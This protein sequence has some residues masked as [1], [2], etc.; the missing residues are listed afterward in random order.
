MNPTEALDLLQNKLTEHGLTARG[1]TGSLDHAERRFGICRPSKKEISLSRTLTSLNSQTEVLD[2]ILHEIAH[3][4]AAIEYNENCG[5]D[6]RWKT[7]CRRIGARPERCYDDDL[8]VPNAPWVF[9]HRVTGEIFTHLHRK[10]KG[11]LS[12]I[13]IRGR[14]SETLGQL[15]I[16]PNPA[17]IE[18]PLSYLDQTNILT[19]QEKILT[20]LEPLAEELGITFSPAKSQYSPSQG[21][22]GLNVA[23]KPN[24]GLTPEERQF[25]ELAPL[26]G[27]SPENY[28]QRFQSGG[29]IFELIAL[30]PRNRKYP[31]IGKNSKGTSYKFPLSVLAE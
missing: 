31:L 26:F 29:Q 27:L 13:F 30:K 1:W 14:K 28:R 7:I 6:E 23:I 19:L 3:A 22:I 24:D 25:R 8:T 2:T 20:Q 10:P 15:E 17:F 21:L 9:A 12:Q 16:Q 4:L 5:H 18:Q 11:D